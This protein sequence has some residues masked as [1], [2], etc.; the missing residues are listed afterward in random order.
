MTVMSRLT[1]R[2]DKTTREQLK[3]VFLVRFSAAVWQSDK[4]LRTGNGPMGS[5]EWRLGT[6]RLKSEPVV[7]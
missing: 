6:G 1:F 3:Q 2:N 4:P 5:G 7:H